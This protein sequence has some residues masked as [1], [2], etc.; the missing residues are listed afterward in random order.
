M[1]IQH[2]LHEA[3]GINNQNAIVRL[4]QE[5]ADVDA[6]DDLNQTPLHIAAKAETEDIA[7]LLLDHGA[8]L[9][10]KDVYGQTPL[11]IS[12]W[13]GRVEVIRLLLERGAV[14]DRSDMQRAVRAATI[15]NGYATIPILQSYGAQIGLVKSIY[16]AD[17]EAVVQYLNAGVDIN[18]VDDGDTILMHALFVA[19]DGMKYNFV[20]MLIEH[21]ADVNA[22]S[23]DGSTALMV[24]A[25]AGRKDFVQFL[26]E[27]G[28]DPGIQ[29]HDGKDALQF[30]M[31]DD[32]N[33]VMTLLLSR[34]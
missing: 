9:Y 2:R 6:F 33:E 34:N 21:G 17:I 12:A 18:Q 23:H 28:A 14:Q 30:A 13:Y 8:D 3:V 7:R 11:L 4:L 16:L 20:P 15:D 19:F 10:T 5:R 27:H 24:A 25:E 31:E 26:L 1:T 32:Q 29:N 22:Q